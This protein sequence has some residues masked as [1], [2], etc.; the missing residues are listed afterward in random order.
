M[1][2]GFRTDSRLSVEVTVRF[3]MN[4]KMYPVS[5]TWRG[6]QY[7]ILAVRKVSYF[8][9][10]A[11]ASPDRVFLVEYRQGTFHL[12][13][14]G[15]RWFVHPARDDK[16]DENDN[17][18]GDSQYLWDTFHAFDLPYFYHFHHKYHKRENK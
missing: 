4:G 13:Y 7:P 8:C 6:R 2:S 1:N 18:A 9:G 17:S 3:A 14:I 11:Y 16:R 12:F 5:V 15:Q 10:D